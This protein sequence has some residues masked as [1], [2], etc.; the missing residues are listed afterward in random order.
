MTHPHVP[1]DP[2]PQDGAF[3]RTFFVALLVLLTGT[4]LFTWL[5]D[6]LGVFGTG[7]VPPV[8][9][10]DRDQ[11]A[12]L[13]RARTP[14]PVALVLGSSRAKTLD[15]RCL[16]RLTG[17]PAFNF[18]VNGAS[19]DDLLAILHYLRATDHT[20]RTIVVGVD[21]EM[22]QGPGGP[23]PG[24]LASRAL[25]P[26]AGT[27]SPDRLTRLG[28]DLLGWQSMS[29]AAHSVWSR[30]THADT[31]PET[32]L[33]PDGRQRYPRIEAER[34]AGTF[35]SA[36]QVG[37]S[38]PG[39]LRRYESFDKLDPDRVGMLRRF[40]GEAHQA[41]IALVV[42]IPPVHP[43]FARAAQVTAWGS[44]T[45]ETVTLLR[46]LH[47]DGLLRYVERDSLPG[48]DA[49]STAFIDALHFLAPAADHLLES[50]FSRPRACA[51]Q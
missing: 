11:K 9:I 49:D 34:L 37:A 40:V 31:F 18:A 22:L 44:R 42:F 8:L 28:A 33:E 2:S 51:V 19:S 23:L 16:S 5:I 25:A 20:P 3:L 30:R 10:A 15:P 29:A 4:A 35:N 38:I 12:A 1:P 32:L 24:L 47:R 39:V 45:D 13:L 41:G 6:P 48:I 27:A 46:S 7:L 43:A 50:L 26:F 21:P 14:L 17:E 36:G